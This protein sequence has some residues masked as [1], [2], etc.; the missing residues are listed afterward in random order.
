MSLNILL[1]LAGYFVFSAAVGA[2]SQPT[3]QQ[4]G[5]FY[6][7]AFR[8][9]NI[10]AAN[11]TRLVASRFPGLPADEPAPGVQLVATHERDTIIAATQPAGPEE[12]VPGH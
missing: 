11:A 3:E 8:F 12:A 10:L 6:G 4:K 7:W 1:A 5:S 2:M 9:L